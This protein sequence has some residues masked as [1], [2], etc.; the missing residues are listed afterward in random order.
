M[1]HVCFQMLMNVQ[2]EQILVLRYA[3]I[4]MVATNVAVIM[5]TELMM[6]DSLAMVSK[7]LIKEMDATLFLC[8]IAGKSLK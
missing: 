6:M 7:V 4:L 3:Q 1:L 8:I 2:M 5:D